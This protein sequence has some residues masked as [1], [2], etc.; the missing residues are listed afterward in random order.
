MTKQ[1]QTAKTQAA[2]AKEA[3]V[4]RED[5]KELTKAP[6]G[7]QPSPGPKPDPVRAERE[8]SGTAT[9]I[10]VK[11]SKDTSVLSRRVFEHEIV[12]LQTL[13]GEENV[14]VLEDTEMQEPIGNATEE[15]DRLMRVYGKKGAKAVREIY[16]TAAALASEAGLKKAAAKA[17]RPG[18]ELRQQSSQRGEG[19]K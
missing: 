5:P 9:T 8:Y 2:K 16:P 14:E 18:L 13:H 4:A 19:V 7:A 11:I 12:V 15:H 3:E 1:T 17:T 6:E 10:R